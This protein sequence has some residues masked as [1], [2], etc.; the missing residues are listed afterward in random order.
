MQSSF[1]FV[2]YNANTNSCSGVI[3]IMITPKSTQGFPT[4][5]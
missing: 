5:K 3:K 2:K 1:N 4:P